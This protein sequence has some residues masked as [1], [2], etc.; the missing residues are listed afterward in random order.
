[1]P[2]LIGT[3]PEQVPVN[4]MLGTAA[5]MDA[6]ALLAAVS[7]SIARSTKT[8]AHTL[9]GADKGGLIDCTGTWTLGFDAAATLGA[10]WWCYVRNTGTGTI[11]ADP[12]GS[13][14]IDGVTSGSIHP[15]MTLLIQCDGTAFH[16]VRVGPR[17]AVAVLTS[18]TSGTVPLGVRSIRGRVQA[19]GGYGTSGTMSG[20]HS[21]AFFN[22]TPGASYTYAIGAAATT[23]GAGGDTT[24]TMG[25]RTI[26]CKGGTSSQSSF[27]TATGGDINIAGSASNTWPVASPLGA[28]GSS[29]TSAAGYGGASNNVN[30]G[31]G[32]IVLE[33]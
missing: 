24:L 15:G 33:Y 30:S 2:Y 8:G 31:A 28:G 19:A 26:T 27:V 1:M 18:G 22:V 6:S 29:S 3:N 25:G 13:E 21:E 4:G 32:V 11:T 10:G 5:F 20:A 12:D 17:V 14:L 7:G 16:C 23:T 9:T